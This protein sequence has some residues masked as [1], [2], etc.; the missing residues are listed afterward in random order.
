MPGMPSPVEEQLK[1]LPAKPGVYLFRDD[2]GQVIARSRDVKAT[3]RAPEP[4]HVHLACRDADAGKR[5]RPGQ[6]LASDRDAEA[7]SCGWSAS[8]RHSS[9]STST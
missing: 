7:I 5:P 2:S 8:R 6:G 9:S 3:D 4:D 1:R